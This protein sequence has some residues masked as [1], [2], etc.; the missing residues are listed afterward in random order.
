MFDRQKYGIVTEFTTVKQLREHMLVYGH[1]F[2][3][4]NDRY[5][6]LS[7]SHKINEKEKRVPWWYLANGDVRNERYDSELCYELYWSTYDF[8][9]IW[10]APIFDGKSFEKNFAEFIFYNE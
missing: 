10:R 7:G 2:F 8:N 1:L 9:E 4:I 3:Y 6:F 5:Y